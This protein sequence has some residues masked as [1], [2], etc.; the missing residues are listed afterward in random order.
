VHIVSFGCAEVTKNNAKK[1]ASR[2]LLQKTVTVQ[3]NFCGYTPWSYIYRTIALCLSINHLYATT[4]LGYQLL[5]S[6]FWFFWQK[7]YRLF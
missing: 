7:P 3:G 4:L 2:Q 6:F 1:I 5:Y